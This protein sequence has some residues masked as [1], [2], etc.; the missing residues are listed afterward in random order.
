MQTIIAFFK[1]PKPKI[2]LVYNEQKHEMNIPKNI[3]ELRKIASEKTLIP[4]EE[5]RML[6]KGKWLEDKN[7]KIPGEGRVRIKKWVAYIA[8][9]HGSERLMRNLMN[10]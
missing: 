7:E 3:E 4:Q 10:T 6:Y 2:T 8:L 5:I 1:T 9:A